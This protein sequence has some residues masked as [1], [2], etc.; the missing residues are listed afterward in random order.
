MDGSTYD[1]MVMGTGITES[2]LS[3]LFSLSGQKI[4]HIDRNGFY[5]DAGASLNITTL[6]A[7]FRP[8]EKPPEELLPN[9]DWNIDQIPKFIMAYG[10]LV[11]MIIKTKVTHYLNW[12]SV[13]ASYVYQW[14]K[15]GLFSSEGGVI[16]KVP[17]NDKEALTSNLMSFLEK[18]RCQN[19]FIYVKN[20]D[21]K[22]PATWDNRNPKQPFVQFVKDFGLDANTVDFLGHAVAL[23]TSDIF[24]QKPAF[25]VFEK[26]RLYIDSA[27]RFGDSHFIYPV[28]GLAGI[29]ESFARKC[30]VY[31]GTFMLNV[32]ISKIDYN[33][34]EKLWNVL[35]IYEGNPVSCKA[36]SIIANPSYLLSIGKESM[37]KKGA[38]ITRVICILYNQPKG[39]DNAQAAQIIIPQKQ[40][41]RHS[42]IYILY[43]GPNHGVCKKG[44]FLAIIS[45]NK[46]HENVDID[47]QVAFGM[48]GP[49]KYRFVTYE[50][51]YTPVD[52]T[53]PNGLAITD[54]LDA[55]SHFESAAENVLEIYKTITGKD[56]DL[57]ITKEDEQEA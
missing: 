40:T 43:I 48:I 27:G 23:Y 50:T 25:E 46:E 55:T 49:V 47:C 26:I 29:P 56:F 44:T 7:K 42:D 34:E 10:K 32:T 53:F 54:T 31:G 30:A 37:L 45:T 6:W 22:N 2:M 24:L 3:G 1:L 17:A 15:G 19:F 20:F 38:T 8:N 11:K 13:D 12:K 39:V 51:E 41:K 5:G 28:Y 36:K 4:L 21:P 52:R 57:T 33:Q 18:R 14:Q 16:E 35:G 9:R